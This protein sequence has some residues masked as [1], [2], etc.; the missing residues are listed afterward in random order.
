MD[1]S[2]GYSNLPYRVSLVIEK[3]GFSS[4]NV[5]PQEAK[6]TYRDDKNLS[7]I[8]DKLRVS[9]LSIKESTFSM[10]PQNSLPKQSNT[11][12]KNEFILNSLK[13]LRVT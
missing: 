11:N 13:V 7:P 10:I 2:V 12:T 1:D 3:N 4:I 6:T 9:S 8:K 5:I